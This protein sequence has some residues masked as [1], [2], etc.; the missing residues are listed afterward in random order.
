MHPVSR[1]YYAA[2]TGKAALRGSKLGRTPGAKEPSCIGNVGTLVARQRASGDCALLPGQSADVRRREERRHVVVAH[3]VGL[4]AEQGPGI[5][6]CARPAGLQ[7]V[8]VV[9]V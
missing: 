3:R 4:L 8:A 7:V 9:P 5:V 1:W 6:V 2:S